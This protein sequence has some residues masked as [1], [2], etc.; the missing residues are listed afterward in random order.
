MWPCYG[1][2]HVRTWLYW[3][4]VSSL[5]WCYAT[6][7]SLQAEIEI[8]PVNTYGNAG[9]RKYHSHQTHAQENDDL[10]HHKEEAAIF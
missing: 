7:L 9:V 2:L 3:E 10:Q 6:V 1:K 4:T 5:Y 8:C